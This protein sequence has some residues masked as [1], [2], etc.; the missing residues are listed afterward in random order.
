MTIGHLSYSA[1]FV[2]S[3]SGSKD[4]TAV[5][6]AV[7]SAQPL[8]S[9]DTVSITR[10]GSQTTGNVT[11]TAFTI[12]TQK[13]FDGATATVTQ[14]N[15]FSATAN[16]SDNLI[17]LES[18]SGN[19]LVGLSSYNSGALQKASPQATSSA[20]TPNASP[21][22]NTTPQQDNAPALSTQSLLQLQVQPQTQQIAPPTI[23]VPQPEAASITPSVT[24]AAH[25]AFTAALSLSPNTNTDVNTISTNSS[26]SFQSSAPATNDTSNNN[27]QNTG[28]GN[29]ASLANASAST[30]RGGNLNVVT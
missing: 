1:V 11:H 14:Q 6:Q 27:Q 26:A 12:T 18:A 19:G 30:I 15:G 10:A 24:A 2:P 25:S 3:V 13:S 28:S 4:A 20:S 16:G 5:Q 7:Q 17:S 23:L 9:S 21:T 8:T 22:T 29:Y